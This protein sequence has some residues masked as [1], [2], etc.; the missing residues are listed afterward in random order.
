MHC[1]CLF[2]SISTEKAKNVLNLLNFSISFF[3]LTFE[4]SDRIFELGVVFSPG[5][6]RLFNGNFLY[7]PKSFVALSLI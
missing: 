7:H 6:F 3:V 2:W 1:A 4:E 5:K